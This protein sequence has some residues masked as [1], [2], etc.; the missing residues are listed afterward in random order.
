[1]AMTAPVYALLSAD[2]AVTALVAGRIHA[3]GYA[4]DNP[5]A[6]Y[7]T[8]Q[9]VSGVPGVYLASRPGYDSFRAQIDC[10]A[11]DAAT[12]QLI[13]AAVRDALET[14]A[15]CVGVMEERD[16]ETGLFRYS[17]DW[18]FIASR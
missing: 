7:V 14:A 16:A 18:M 11:A 9:L 5:Q 17:G 3:Q 2:A 15:S 13:A 10:W 4:G 6:P 8:W 1:M 12:A